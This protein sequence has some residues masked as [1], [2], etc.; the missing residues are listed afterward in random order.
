MAWLQ[1]EVATR[2]IE[3][4]ELIF[5]DPPTFSNSKR[6]EDVF[7]V[8]RDHVR[9]LQLTMRLLTD[10]GTLYF[11]NNFRKFGLDEALMAQFEIEDISAE[12]IGF[13][14]QRNQKIHRCWR[15]RHRNRPES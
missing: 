12:T 6:S 8:Q 5:L 13:D 1:E 2:P 4:Y 9:M 11:S 3:Q 10:D 15:I 14:Y 7:D